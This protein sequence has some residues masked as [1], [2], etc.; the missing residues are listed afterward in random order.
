[1]KKLLLFLLIV[2]S[3]CSF[4]GCSSD[5]EEN[6]MSDLEK[7]EDAKLKFMEMANDYGVIIKLSGELTPKD[8]DKIKFD[9]VETFIKGLANVN[10]TVRYTYENRGNEYR[11]IEDNQTKKK[12]FLTR[13]VENYSYRTNFADSAG[14]DIYN[15]I[16]ADRMWDCR[17][18]ASWNSDGKY[19]VCCVNI[20]AQATM[21]G[22]S[23]VFTA[24]EDY[25][26]E[27]GGG[28]FI[29]EGSVPVKYIVGGTSEISSTIGFSGEASPSGSYISWSNEGY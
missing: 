3:S 2:I 9:E 16:S 10:K 25:W 27:S 29:F 1:M 8:V 13:G 12:K 19:D 4:V 28:G 24:C 7:V 22:L 23:D 21:T 15:V 18:S 6:E 14:I 11:L 17:C 26:R 20:S 5:F